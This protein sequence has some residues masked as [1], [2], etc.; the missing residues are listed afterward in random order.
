MKTIT[1]QNRSQIQTA[2]KDNLGKVLMSERD[3][4]VIARRW[5]VDDNIMRTLRETGETFG[6]TPERVRQIEYKFFDLIGGLD[7]ILTPVDNK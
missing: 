7:R 2:V 3:K 6:I 1:T 4:L 5:G